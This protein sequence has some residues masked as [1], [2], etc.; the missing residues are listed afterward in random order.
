MRLN[1]KVVPNASKT[2]VVEENNGFKV[3]L[4]A[5][6]VDGKANKMLLE[7]LAEYFNV[8]PRNIIIKYG[9]KS[10]NKIVEILK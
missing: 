5:P 10:R 9:E 2:K 3:Y 8:K 1:I 7:T 4:T 6:A